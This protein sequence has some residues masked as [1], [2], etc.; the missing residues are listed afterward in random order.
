M[1]EIEYLYHHR[2]NEIDRWIDDEGLTSVAVPI[3]SDC[4]LFL[5]LQ[6]LYHDD[7]YDHYAELA[8]YEI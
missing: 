8:K 4:W 6:Q 3:V 2:D 7:R 1:R 5:Y